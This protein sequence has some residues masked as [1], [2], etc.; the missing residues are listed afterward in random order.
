MFRHLL[1]PNCKVSVGAVD[2]VTNSVRSPSFSNFTRA[3]NKKMNGHQARSI[4]RKAIY[5]GIPE[6]YCLFLSPDAK[7][8]NNGAISL[9]IP[10]LQVI[11]QP[12]PLSDD[13]EQTAAAVMVL[14][15]NLEMLRQI[16]DSLSKNRYLHFRR[17]GIILMTF[18]GLDD[19]LL[20]ICYQH[21]DTPPFR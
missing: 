18:M 7:F 13:L 12:S 8:L 19:F 5:P 4:K 9:N 2:K 6:I 16:R 15:M 14:F 21:S 3:P 20:L 1:P 11:Q 10:T 17:T